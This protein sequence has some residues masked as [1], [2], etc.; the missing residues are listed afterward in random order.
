[1]SRE[2]IRK[3]KAL[4]ELNLAKGVKDNKKGFFKNIGD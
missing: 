2:N 3:A 1:M 4:I